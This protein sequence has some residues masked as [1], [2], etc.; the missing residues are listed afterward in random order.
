VTWL[1]ANNTPLKAESEESLV[2][3][4]KTKQPL[5]LPL[6]ELKKHKVNQVWNEMYNRL[7][8]YAVEVSVNSVSYSWG[9]DRES[10]ENIMGINTAI[11]ADILIPNPRA[12]T[13]K[14]ALLPVEC[15]HSDFI[16]IGGALLSAK[17]DFMQAYFIHKATIM[18]SDNANTVKTYDYSSGWPDDEE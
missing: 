1:S 7:E 6:A 8:N 18:M 5:A 3:Y 16:A 15:T 12:W 10:R 17:D 11:N 13:P 4:L 9:C 14:G 2:A